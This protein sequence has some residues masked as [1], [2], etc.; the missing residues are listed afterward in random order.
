MTRNQKRMLVGIAFGFASVPLLVTQAHAAAGSLPTLVQDIGVSLLVAGVLAILFARLKIPSIAAFI[1]AGVLVGP[2]VLHQVTEPENIEAIAQ[3][4]FILLLFVI[5]LE[6]DIRSLLKGGKSILLA[7]LI[8][9][10]ATLL[11]GL[12]IT[13][14]LIFF[15]MGSLFAGMP[16]APFYIGVTIA[17][18]SSLLVVK[19]FQEQFE[20]DTQPGRIALVILIFQDIWAIAITILQP[21]LARPEFGAIVFSFLGIGIVIVIATLL[22]RTVVSIAFGWIAKMPELILLGAVSW[23]FAVIALGTNIDNATGMLGFNLHMSVGAGM[24]ALIA[25]ATIASSP[26]SLE[27]VT[28]VGLVKDFFISLFFVGLG[29]SMPALDGWAVPLMALVVAFIAVISRQLVFFPLFYACG[30][31]QRTA[32]VTSVRLAQISEFALVIAFLGLELG[33][34]S[35]D[36]ASVIILAF[37]FTAVLTSPLFKM[38]YAIH[39]RIKP[40]LSAIGFREPAK[41]KQDGRAG[42]ELMILGIHRD[43]SS[44]L[45]EL[46]VERPEMLAKTTV[47]DFNVS[48]HPKVRELGIHIEYGDISNEE[49]LIHAGVDHAKVILCTISDDL[50]RG[51][52]NRDLVKTL[53]RLNPDALII[54]N[55]IDMQASEDVREAGADFVYMARLEVASALMRAIGHALDGSLAV[56]RDDIE[57]RVGSLSSR[58]EVMT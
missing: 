12:L 25:G 52:T 40:F 36:L 53:R 28:K 4:G 43:A 15:G 57:N 8:Q 47:V 49:T 50:L 32:Q 27:I 51:I 5:G 18:S 56:H 37:V 46:S 17:G 54:S 13:H 38:A 24:G 22:A 33:H 23:C 6:I 1:L 41:E 55:A 9:Y 11:F 14:A 2:Q 26:F 7:G 44:F 34:I 31:D 39:S 19:L 21:S 58:R 20:L 48:L 42:T 35:Q 45:H 16:L 29:I 30:I 3:I 10:P